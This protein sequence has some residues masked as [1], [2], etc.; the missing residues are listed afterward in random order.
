MRFLLDTHL[1]L[2]GIAEPDRVP[3]RARQLADDPGN[4]VFVSAAAIWEIAIK[5]ARNRGRTDDMPISGS[6][7][8]A[9][10]EG[11]EIE[12]LDITPDHAAAVD[13]LPLLHGDPFDRIMIVQARS[14][15]M[16]LLTIDKA[17]GAYGD[18]VLVV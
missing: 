6:Q 7:A 8:L 15:D 16:I 9:M 12:L 18:C 1:L 13:G 17:L 3:V 2:W 11:A 10:T 14:E 5:F 4:E